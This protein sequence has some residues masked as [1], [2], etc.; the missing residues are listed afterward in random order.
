LGAAKNPQLW[1]KL[2]QAPVSLISRDEKGNIDVK[3]TE[4][5]IDLYMGSLIEAIKKGDFSLIKNMP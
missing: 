1:S 3:K 4:D 2:E 5:N